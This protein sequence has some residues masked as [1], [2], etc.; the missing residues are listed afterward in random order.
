[1]SKV[2]PFI[3]VN[4]TSASCCLF[5]LL[6]LLLTYFTKKNMNNVDNKLYK[7]ML[8]VNCLSTLFYICFYTTDIIAAF[9]PNTDE[10]YPIVYF[11]SK[12]APLMICFWA[13]FFAVY[14]YY[15][16]HEHDKEFV[17]RFQNNEKKF[18]RKVYI[19]LA[20]I[21]VLNFLEHSEV[22]LSTGIENK[23][24]IVMNIVLYGCLATIFYLI[25][26]H[27]KKLDKKKALPVFLIFP[28]S[29]VSMIGGFIGIPIVFLFI[30]MTA[31]NHL[32]FHTIENPDVKLIN[33][34]ELAKSQAEK[35]SQA[36]SDF[37]SSMSH[38]LRTPIN[39]I[40]GLS[41]IIIQNATDQDMRND[42]TDIY[43]SST[44]LLEL[45]DGI[46]AIN[47]IEASEIEIIKKNYNTNELFDSI[48]KSTRVR[49][50][51][52][53]IELKTYFSE[54]IPQVLYG[55]NDKIKTILNNLLSNAAK[56]TDA[57]TIKL[58]VDALKTKD[59]F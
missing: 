33:E 46:L 28:I 51:D 57:G 43:N 49:I 19:V 35:A 10:I 24:L 48:L 27:F 36:K 31:L 5:F 18:F 13:I 3:Y 11:F 32:M 21:A 52:K 17:I 54:D 45:V 6:F 9:S 40:T 14:I 58:S 2:S 38:E 34:L 7:H 44:K 50:G 23:L 25:I 12:L 59:S 20:V 29:F 56:Y 39:A 8:I 1:M 53:P 15:I 16:T 22:I 4:I 41:T 37:L 30:M 42:A 47:K 26:K 55:D